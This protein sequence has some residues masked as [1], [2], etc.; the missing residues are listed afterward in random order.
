[1]AIWADWLGWEVEKAKVALVVGW[2]GAEVVR[3]LGAALVGAW[4]WAEVQAALVVG[5][6]DLVWV[7][8]LAE[9]LVSCPSVLHGRQ[10]RKPHS[11][12]VSDP[13]LEQ[14]NIG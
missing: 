1:M 4:G 6:G 10:E 11:V 8:G 7:V 2:V 12:Y 13:S 9:V 14:S 5:L 3:V